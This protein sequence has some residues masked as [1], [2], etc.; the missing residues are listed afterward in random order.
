MPSLSPRSP[1][2][3]HFASAP[4]R[5]RPPRPRPTPRRR[6]RPGRVHRRMNRH[7]PQQ[8]PTCRRGRACRSSTS[9]GRR[10]RS[11]TA[12]ASPVLVELFATWCSNCRQQ[13]PKTQEAAV[14]MGDGAAVIALSVETDLAPDAVA[15]YAVDNELPDIRFA[16]MSPELLAAFVDTFGNTAANPPSTPKIVIDADWRRRRADDGSGEHRRARRA[17]HRGV[18]AACHRDHRGLIALRVRLR[19]GVHPRQRRDPQQRLSAA[20]VSGARRDAL[21]APRQPAVAL[22]DDEPR[23]RRPRRHRRVHGRRRVRPVSG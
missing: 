7:H 1:S 10:S 20:A 17:A 15:Q 6:P 5:R 13:L 9:T 4:R 21:G 2:S 12:S 22:V 11:P 18:G 14:R 3:P 16:V 23:A 8:P 19:R